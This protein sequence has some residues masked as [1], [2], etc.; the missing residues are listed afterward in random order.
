[1]CQYDPRCNTKEHRTIGACPYMKASGYAA[2]RPTM[3][4]SPPP[5]PARAETGRTMKQQ[6]NWTD[7]WTTQGSSLLGFFVVLI[8]PAL[9]GK[10]TWQGLVLAFLGV[11]IPLIVAGSLMDRCNAWTL[12]QA[13]C[14][15]RARGLGKRCAISNH[16]APW[17]VLPDTLALTAL[18]IC[19]MNVFL[20]VPILQGML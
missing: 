17:W 5:R 2:P 3:A 13:R 4:G 20:A 7:T 16:A 15:K 14:R 9:V 18:G 19:V 6:A 1:M 12:Q 10:D 8:G 11:A